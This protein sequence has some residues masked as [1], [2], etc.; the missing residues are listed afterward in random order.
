MRD[1]Q[2]A[3]SQL[4]KKEEQRPNASPSTPLP[5]LLTPFLAGSSSMYRLIP[6]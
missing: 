4:S 3:V 6:I 1:K 5:R 2:Q